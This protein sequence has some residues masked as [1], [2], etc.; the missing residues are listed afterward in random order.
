[1]FSGNQPGGGCAFTLHALE[2]GEHGVCNDL[3]RDPQAV[4]WRADALERG[5]RGMASLPLKAGGEVIGIFNLYAGEPDFFDAQE[6][7]LLDELA[8]DISFKLEVCNR[9]TER[10]RVEQVSRE[11]EERFRQLAENIQEVFW[12]NDPATN[13]VLYV[14][15]AYERIWGRTC[16]SLYRF[17]GQ[18]AVFDSP[19]RPCAGRARCRGHAEDRCLQRDIPY[20]AA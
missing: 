2:T 7:R 12:M 5:Y 14:S 13:Q 18:L 6:L 20:S 17:A 9:E 8:L 16:A 10:R 1:M 4:L 3:V 15:P 19:R 11:S